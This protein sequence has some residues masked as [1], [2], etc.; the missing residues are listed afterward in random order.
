MSFISGGKEIASVLRGAGEQFIINPQGDLT[1][2][3]ANPSLALGDGNS[4]WY[5][6]ADNQ[7]YMSLGGVHYF[8]FT[9]NGIDTDLAGGPRLKR[10]T[11]SATNPTLLPDKSD[12]NTGI[13]Q[14]SGDQLSLIAGSIEGLRIENG[15]NGTVGTHLFIPDLTTAP[16][17]NPTGGGYL[18]TEAGALKYRG[19]SGTVTTIALN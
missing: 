16:T 7:I 12:T 13:G 17:G 10:G 19:S 15:N 1:G 18:Y 8:T 11:A 14:A 3:A 9:A 2:T 6:N 4:G 5:E